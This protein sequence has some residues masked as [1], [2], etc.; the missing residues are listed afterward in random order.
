MIIASQ[1]SAWSYNAEEYACWATTNNCVHLPGEYGGQ[2]YLP[3]CIALF[4]NHI[5][6]ANYFT[7]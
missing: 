2:S 6:N 4:Y 3:N 7:F 1:A 5:F